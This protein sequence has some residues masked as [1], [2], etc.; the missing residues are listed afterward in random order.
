MKDF[1]LSVCP[2]SNL[3]GLL[4]LTV[5][6]VLAILLPFEEA[7][8]PLPSSPSPLPPQENRAKFRM[9]QQVTNGDV[10]STERQTENSA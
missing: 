3:P 10:I 8:P 9:C 5:I 2:F 4:L 1:H 7:L 6:A